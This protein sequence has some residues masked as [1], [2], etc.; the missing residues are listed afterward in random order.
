MIPFFKD[1]KIEHQ[2]QEFGFVK[3]AQIDNKIIQ[4]ILDVNKK[5]N[6]PDDVGRNFNVGLNCNSLEKYH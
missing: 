4:Q 3:F 1:A 2:F 6:I 5:L